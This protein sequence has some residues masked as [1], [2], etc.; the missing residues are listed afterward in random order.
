M[1]PRTPIITIVGRPNVGKS[2]L[3]NRILRAKRAVVEDMPGVTRD[4]NYGL[5]EHYTI[6]FL[7]VDTGGFEIDPVEDLAKQVVE[8]TLVAAEES[9]VI[10]ALYD[11][12][13]GCQPAD[14]EVTTLLR[15]FSKPVFYAVNKCDG[16]EQFGRVADFYS[17]GIEHFIDVSALHGR[18]VHAL[19]E[20]VLKGIPNY[21]ALRA[22]N[23]ARKSREAAAAEVAQ[24]AAALDVESYEDE[25]EEGDEEAQFG[26]EENDGIAADGAPVSEI[27]FAP[28]FL[29]DAD[30]SEDLSDYIKRHRLRGL[31][32]YVNPNAG[33]EL[34]DDFEDDVPEEV[35]IEC[36]SL[37]LVGKP[38]VGKSTLLNTLTGER[39]AITSPI[40]GTTRDVLDL[41]IT[42]DNQQ[43]RIVDTAGL[44]KEGKVTDSVERYSAMRSL[45]ALSEC[46]VA[47]IVIDAS[48]G[49]TDQDARIVGLAHE[50]GK[51]IVLVVNKWDLVEKSHTTVHAFTTKIREAFKFA[52][53]APIVYVSALS[54]RRC[55]RI[56]QAAKHVARERL[57]R[58]STGKLNRVM[59]RCLKR[60][61]PPAYRGRPIKLLYAN[62]VD[63]GPPRF[64]LFFNYPRALHFTF[65]RFLKNGIREEF[66][67][68]GTDIKLVPRK[69]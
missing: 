68:E 23:L 43:Y 25:G 53:Y 4:R 38:N 18:G 69:K 22:S 7:L 16:E 64:V 35:V 9:D 42:R 13:V 37:A 32:D 41:T 63:V 61:S 45:Q 46:D 20:E 67:F 58:V 8:Q 14:E 54:G 33:E 29:P 59:T 44:R 24:E 56:I 48:E 6:P 1:A 36:I 12:A 34:D 10:I 2:T 3:F 11:G 51:G 19:V 15:R 66:G 55:P 50:Q 62:Q 57:K 39:R 65:L 52:P 60:F 21:D 31:R 30:D 5:V 17:L 26:V 49:P 27:E 40:A 47:L 28:V